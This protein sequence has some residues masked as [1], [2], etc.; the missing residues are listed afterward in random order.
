MDIDINFPTKLAS[1]DDVPEPFLG[2]L[3]DRISSKERV[4]SLIYSPVFSTLENLPPGSTPVT[5]GQILA[6]ASVLAVLDNRWLVATEEEDGIKV[7]EATFFD[8]LFLELTSIL[9][10]G[11][12]RIYFAAVGTYYAA[13]LP[14]N[15]VGEEVY[16]EAI[17]L[18]LDG[19]D[20]KKSTAYDGNDSILRT[21]PLKFR[22]EAERYRPKGQCL[23]TATRWTCLKGELDDTLC[24][25]GA[26]L[27]TERELVFISE[28]KAFPRQHVGDLHKFGGI[29][30]YF[31]LIRLSD[32]HINHHGHFGVLAL[33]VHAAH[34]S[35]KLEIVFPSDREKAV[36]KTM[37]FA[38]LGQR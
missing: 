13:T 21:W 24:P 34:G 22:L 1:V 36:Q 28:Q 27:I 29:I 12:L 30:T 19:I 26:L 15:T 8:T 31:P 17:G 37:Q 35:E 32:F 2:T 7:E 5:P 20:Q 10:S 23:T 38:L 4:Q 25:S 6:P 18:I 33:L 11:E 9:L 14:F 16:R 3:K